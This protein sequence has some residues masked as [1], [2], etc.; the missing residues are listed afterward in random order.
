M[1]EQ[2]GQQWE[3]RRE[4]F[5]ALLSR[6]AVGAAEAMAL[7]GTCRAARS[8]GVAVSASL[9]AVRAV[10]V[11]DPNN[12]ADHRCAKLVAPLIVD[13]EPTVETLKDGTESSKAWWGAA[14]G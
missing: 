11:V 1:E 3:P 5:E 4:L 12:T 7:L 13:L 6:P 2:R 14:P 8:V 9:T 10:A